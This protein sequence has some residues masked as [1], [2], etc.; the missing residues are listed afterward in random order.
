ML[1]KARKVRHYFLSSAPRSSHVLRT[2][3]MAVSLV[4]SRIAS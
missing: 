2:A 3:R 1:E 4:P